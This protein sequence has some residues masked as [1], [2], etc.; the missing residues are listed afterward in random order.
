[1]TINVFKYKNQQEKLDWL[2]ALFVEDVFYRDHVEVQ[3][4]TPP[5]P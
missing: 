2:F 1:M 3:E 5:P 4:H